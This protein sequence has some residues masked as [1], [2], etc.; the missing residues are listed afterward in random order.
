MAK[1]KISKPNSDLGILF[2][3]KPVSKE[4]NVNYP[5]TH[6]MQVI[7]PKNALGKE[8]KPILTAPAV[9]QRKEK[10]LYYIPLPDET[11]FKKLSEIL[12]PISD[13][14]INL[15]SYEQF[16]KFNISTNKI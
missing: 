10:R 16:K 8:L 12:V 13:L 3:V 11:S 5:V 7:T 4:F 15:F 2:D 14:E 9:T 6:V 1:A